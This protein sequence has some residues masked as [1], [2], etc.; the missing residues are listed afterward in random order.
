M[1]LAVLNLSL[2][3][4]PIYYIPECLKSLRVQMAL[5]AEYERGSNLWVICAW[6]S[7]THILK[8]LPGT[9]RL[10]GTSVDAL[11]LN[12]QDTS[13]ILMDKTIHEKTKMWRMKKPVWGSR[14]E[15]KVCGFLLLDYIA[16][17]RRMK[18]FSCGFIVL[19]LEGRMHCA[20]TANSP[21]LPFPAPLF[22][23]FPPP[24]HP[25]NEE[26]LGWVSPHLCPQP[27][28]LSQLVTP[29]LCK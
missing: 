1:L 15:G 24:S 3:L 10:A 5:A 25:C 14:T 18:P 17:F 23:C 29:L 13:W 11:P 16:V 21:P 20:F 8:R 19:L 6:K 22:L 28:A 9:T 2:E 26:L 12:A 7:E 27:I 4:P